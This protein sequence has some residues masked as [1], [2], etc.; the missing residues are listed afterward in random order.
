MQEQNRGERVFLAAVGVIIAVYVGVRFGIPLLAVLTGLS[1]TPPPVPAFALGIYMLCALIG[2][3]VYVSS[4]E[5][6]WNSFL[7]PVI[8]V[9]VVRPGGLGRS[10]VLILGLLPLLV[11]WGT[12]RRVMPSRRM[13][14]VLRVQHPAQPDQFAALENPYGATVGEERAALEREGVVLY[15]KNC[16]PCHGTKA[17]GGGPLARGQRLRPIDFTDAGTIATVVES[18]PFWRIEEGWSGLPGL[19]TPWNSA[20]PSWGEE[21]EDHEIWRIIMVEY[22]IAGTEPRKP[23]SL[24]H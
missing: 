8:S 16:R 7:K 14:A 15:Q 13:P 12:W 9:F 17:D 10:Q 22:R 6:R 18:Y 5:R 20:M 11:G 4:D 24:E 3:L 1:Q 2:T 23:E 19:A 21:L